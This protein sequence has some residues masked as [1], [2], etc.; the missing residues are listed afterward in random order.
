MA[1]KGSTSSK[2]KKKDL[3]IIAQ[4]VGRKNQDTVTKKVISAVAKQPTKTKEE[5]KQ[6][7][8]TLDKLQKS[9]KGGTKSSSST[10]KKTSPVI[11]QDATDKYDDLYVTPVQR[12]QQEQQAEERQRIIGRRTPLS[13]TLKNT[14]SMTGGAR[15]TS[16]GGVTGILNATNQAV[17]DIRNDTTSPI[18][19]SVFQNAINQNSGVA[20][21]QARFNLGNAVTNGALSVGGIANSEQAKNVTHPMSFYTRMQTHSVSDALLAAISGGDIGRAQALSNGVKLATAIAARLGGEGAAERLQKLQDVSSREQAVLSSGIVGSVES[22]LGGV[23]SLGNRLLAKGVRTLGGNDPTNI[24]AAEALERSANT[25]AKYGLFGDIQGHMQQELD[26][27]YKAPETRAGKLA[28][29]SISAAGAMLPWIGASGLASAAAAG[30]ESLAAAE[31]TSKAARLASTTAQSAVPVLAPMALSATEQGIK[32]ALNDGATEKQAYTYGMAVGTLSVVTEHF[33]EGIPGVNTGAVTNAITKRLGNS[34]IRRAFALAID[35][36]GEGFEEAAETVLTPYAKRFIYDSDAAKATPEEIA[37]SFLTGVFTSAIL[38][39]GYRV[40]GRTAQAAHALTQSQQESISSAIEEITQEET[41]SDS[42]ASESEQRAETQSTPQ[43]QEHP[44][45][46]TNIAARL[47]Q[48]Q[49]NVNTEQTTQTTEQTAQ[50]T[51]ETVYDRLRKR[52]ENGE[53]TAKQAEN[54]LKNGAV[55]EEQHQQLTNTLQLNA[56][57]EKTDTPIRSNAQQARAFY[58]KLNGLTEEQISE[59]VQNG[60]ISLDDSAE[61]LNHIRQY[62]YLMERAENGNLSFEQAQRMYQ[63]GAV[64]ADEY[65][66]LIDIIRPSAQQTQTLLDNEMPERSEIQDSSFRLLE[67]DARRQGLLSRAEENALQNQYLFE[68]AAEIGESMRNIEAPTEVS[69]DERV[70]LQEQ[71]AQEEGRLTAAEQTAQDVMDNTFSEERIGHGQYDE[72]LDDWDRP[73]DWLDDNVFDDMRVKYRTLSLDEV[74]EDLRANNEYIEDKAREYAGEYPEL[75]AEQIEKAVNDKIE[76]EFI[77]K[78]QRSAYGQMQ[79][80]VADMFRTLNRTHN[81]TV[82][83]RSDL[84]REAL[85]RLDERVRTDPEIREAA[86]ASVYRVRYTAETEQEGHFPAEL[87]DAAHTARSFKRAAA[88]VREIAYE[89]A[90]TPTEKMAVDQ[91]I[92]LVN[93]C[94]DEGSLSY[95]W[96]SRNTQLPHDI[97]FVTDLFVEEWAAREASK[98][99][100]Y[101]Q[102]SKNV[103]NRNLA[104]EC[105]PE[106]GRAHDSFGLKFQLLTPKR[107]VQLLYKKFPSSVSAKLYQTFFGDIPTHEAERTRYKDALNKK[108]HEVSKGMNQYE[109]AYT[110]MLI[111]DQLVDSDAVEAFYLTYSKQIRTERCEQLRDT[112]REVFAEV[113]DKLDTASIRSGKGAVGNFSNQYTPHV[114]EQLTA[115]ERFLRKLGVTKSKYHTLAGTGAAVLDKIAGTATAETQADTAYEPTNRGELPNRLAGKTERFRPK[116]RWSGHVLTRTGTE[117]GYNIVEQ[118]NEYIDPV[119]DVIYFSDDIARLRALEDTIRYESSSQE[120]RLRYDEISNSAVDPLTKQAQ[121]DELNLEA[122]GFGDSY[123]K[124][125]QLKGKLTPDNNLTGFLSWLRD[126]TNNLAGKK[127]FADRDFETKVGR[128]LFYSNQKTMSRIATNMASTFSAATTNFIP[129][130]QVSAETNPFNVLKAIK[131]TCKSAVVHDGFV[132]ESNF[133]TNRFGAEKLNPTVFDKYLDAIGVIDQF[134]SQVVTRSFYYEGLKAGY[135]HEQ[136]ID[137]ADQHAADLMASRS[138]SE[139]PL[140]FQRQNPIYKA[141]SMFQ[142]EVNNNIWHL[143]TDTKGRA[144]EVGKARAAL[145]VGLTFAG[146]YAFNNL[147]QMIFGYR[148]ESLDLIEWFREFFDFDREDDEKQSIVE[149]AEELAHNAGESLPF[150]GGVLGGGRVPVTGIIPGGDWEGFKESAKTMFSTET[151]AE[152]KLNEFINQWTKPLAAA[153][154]AGSSQLRKTLGGVYTMANGGTY[155]YNSDNEKYLQSTAD[156]D[157][158]LQWAQAILGGKTALGNQREFYDGMEKGKFSGLNAEQTKIYDGIKDGNLDIGVD[159]GVYS[160]TVQKYLDLQR[161]YKDKD[162]QRSAFSVYVN[163]LDIPEENKLVLYSVVAGYIPSS[164]KEKYEDGLEEIRSGKTGTNVTE[165]Q[166]LVASL[167]ES[168]LYSQITQADEEVGL[169]GKGNKYAQVAYEMREFLQDFISD[170]QISDVFGVAGMQTS[171]PTATQEEIDTKRWLDE[172]IIGSRLNSGADDSEAR[173]LSDGRTVTGPYALIGDEFDAA[174]YCVSLLSTEEW[175]QASRLK[176]GG[177]DWQTIRDGFEVIDGIEKTTGENPYSE[178]YLGDDNDA[179]YFSEQQN[180]GFALHDY[181]GMTAA[182]KHQFASAVLGEKAKN[183]NFDGDEYDFTAS[184][185]LNKESLERWATLDT[186]LVSKEE[187]LSTAVQLNFDWHSYSNVNAGDWKEYQADAFKRLALAGSKDFTAA[188]KKEIGRVVLNDKENMRYDDKN[189]VTAAMV[190]TAAGVKWAMAHA[191]GFDIDDFTG[192]W[193]GSSKYQSKAEKRNALAELGY[194]SS[195]IDTFLKIYWTKPA[196]AMQYTIDP[197]TGDIATWGPALGSGYHS[198]RKRRYYRSRRRYHRSRRSGGGSGGGASSTSGSA[199]GKAWSNAAYDG[200]SA[201]TYSQALAAVELSDPSNVVQNVVDATGWSWITAKVFCNKIKSSSH[202]E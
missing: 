37:D 199:S 18:S 84:Y 44:K 71:Q 144:A 86:N 10:Q 22:A 126:Y 195:Q 73:G 179:W 60:E 92:K 93:K 94:V 33:S 45:L 184:M 198:Y 91:D 3:N 196:I 51:Q 98:P 64:T 8:K 201:D 149:N 19:R 109:Y 142:V 14:L 87:R 82:E 68:R 24:A 175:E 182:Q 185:V 122:D 134:T 48:V 78:M 63:L 197:E 148:P 36:F 160:A 55:T 52:A 56:E 15:D 188:Q 143:T 102:A 7:E 154:P 12:Q 62:D 107:A 169:E 136:A 17:Q 135:T 5:Q 131:S 164:R 158:P 50:D 65:S 178:G 163:A 174:N 81:A 28:E 147:F 153:L 165:D 106:I 76:Q 72:H 58:E 39:A 117:T 187:L 47:A 180:K 43:E 124:V 170:D 176:T 151:T 139:L 59:A 191:Y 30:S 183:W 162:E 111:E 167:V 128:S 156:L 130:T 152:Q 110:S 13:D 69:T 77:R 172:K 133:L 88:G 145:G 192:M 103:Y 132:N 35:T 11:R 177:M 138:K 105:V 120:V 137:Y 113:W 46:Q 141:F 23:S 25:T 159:F 95:I 42:A 96:S 104:K 100:W 146:F 40:S 140:A 80:R 61:F 157:D 32:E 173:E 75:S 85:R 79:G 99:D 171:K 168:T 83:E 194:S 74:L 67:Q 41:K 121:I 4:S 116:T 166:Y 70:Q 97:D 31:L 150:I 127:Q 108:I 54:A 123:S 20:R 161:K 129:I 57:T 202:K 101:Y 29:Q 38:Q 27:A 26:E 193:K 115:T 114:F 66:A 190:S 112:Y 21:A 200:Y 90:D 119:L 2:D 9:I 6:K 186:S 89:K 118:W 189:T 53:L 1:K 155:G 16:G 49:Q 34:G 181:D 125:S